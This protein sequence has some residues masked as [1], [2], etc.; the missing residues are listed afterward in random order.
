[1]PISSN[2]LSLFHQATTS[3]KTILFCSLLDS[4]DLTADEALAL[5]TTI[6][7][8][9]EQGRGD[10]GLYVR[11]AEMMESLHQRIPDV[12]EQVA[13][14][15]QSLHGGTRSVTK[16]TPSGD[17]LAEKAEKVS[18][19]KEAH[20]SGEKAEAAETGEAGEAEV[21]EAGEP[22]EEEEKESEGKESSEAKESEK[23]EEKEEEETEAEEPH[24]GKADEEELGLHPFSGQ[25]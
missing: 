9:L 1:M 10:R 14:K 13:S 5:L 7:A 21:G 17:F 25:D 12:Y 8:E 11:Y 16:D 24:G 18:E 15:W 6:H 3:D 20:E 19:Q 22:E 4:G 2:H 23:E